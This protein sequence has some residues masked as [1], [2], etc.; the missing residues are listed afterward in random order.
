MADTAVM[1]EELD[2]LY[3]ALLAGDTEGYLTGYRKNCLTLDRDVLLVKNGLSTP[4]HALDVDE[5]LG[6]LVR[7]PDGEEALIRSG[8]ASVRGLAGYAE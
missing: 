4:A 8:E 3:G 1:V 2:R 6:L 5:A 7:Y